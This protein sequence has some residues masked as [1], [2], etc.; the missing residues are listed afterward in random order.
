MCESVGWRLGAINARKKR[1]N[2]PE[3]NLAK[4]NLQPLNLMLNPKPYT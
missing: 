3:K 2:I 4:K 1:I